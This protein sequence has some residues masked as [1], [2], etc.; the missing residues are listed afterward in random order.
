MEVRKMI[1]VHVKKLTTP[2]LTAL[3]MSARATAIVCSLLVGT[4][5]TAYAQQSAD[6]A[7][8]NTIV[9]TVID[10]GLGA[11]AGRMLNNWMGNHKNN[12]LATGIGAGVGGTAGYVGSQKCHDQY[13]RQQQQAL[14][15]YQA[16]VAYQAQH[17]VSD[18]DR[19]QA[20]DAERNALNIPVGNHLEWDGQTA[21]G[22][23]YASSE[24]Q[25]GDH[26]F[27]RIQSGAV[28]KATGQEVQAY[29]DFYQDAQGWHQVQ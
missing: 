7:C 25:V 17:P 18:F 10:A 15:A 22:V 1:S 3:A 20:I 12:N 28:I 13:E 23:A 8:G 24:K 6:D 27:R 4:Y 21:R 26:I 16:Q 5:S 9:S 2:L 11:G 19:Q 14:Q 29:S